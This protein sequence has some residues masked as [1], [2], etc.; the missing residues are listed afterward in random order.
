[1]AIATHMDA[2]AGTDFF[3]GE[4]ITW[5]DLVTYYVLIFLHL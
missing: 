2:L 1:L 4:V 3:I 5:R